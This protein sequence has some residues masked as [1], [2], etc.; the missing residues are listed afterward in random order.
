MSANQEKVTVNPR[1]SEAAPDLLA[2]AKAFVE[3]FR[4]SDMAPE[5]EC[6]ELY[7]QAIKAI[8]KTVGGT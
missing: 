2:F 3:L 5:D 6:H 1:L 8:A 7:N 4:D